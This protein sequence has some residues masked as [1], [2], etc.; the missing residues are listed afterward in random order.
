[1]ISTRNWKKKIGFDNKDLSN[2]DLYEMAQLGAYEE[3]EENS[4]KNPEDEP[5]DPTKNINL[6][7]L[8]V[9]LSKANELHDLIQDLD[10]VSDRRSKAQNDL[11]GI[12]KCY[13]SEQSD[14]QMEKAKKRKQTDIGNFFLKKPKQKAKNLFK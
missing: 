8:G 6:D 12:I 3:D 5:D 2:E 13:K 1:M 10:P 4:E 11:Q 14:Q 9:I 7:Q